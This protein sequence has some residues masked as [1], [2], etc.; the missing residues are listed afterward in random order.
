[1]RHDAAFCASFIT[2]TLY[3]EIYFEREIMGSYI[4][5]VRHWPRQTPKRNVVS[6]S[7]AGGAQNNRCKPFIDGLQRFFIVISFGQPHRSAIPRCLQ[8]R[9]ALSF[10]MQSRPFSSINFYC[11]QTSA[12]LQRLL[13]LLKNTLS[14]KA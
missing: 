7:L 4:R 10:L 5:S 8:K 11:L 1:M 9:A 2:K 6:S 3:P 12:F 13:L 14:F